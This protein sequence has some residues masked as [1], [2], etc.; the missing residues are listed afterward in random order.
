MFLLSNWRICHTPV[1]ESFPN[2]LIKGATN[3]LAIKS[4]NTHSNILYYYF[5]KH[6]QWVNQHSYE[7]IATLKK[8]RK[9]RE[10]GK[11]EKED[12]RKWEEKVERKEGRRKK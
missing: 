9:G 5:R 4:E 11:E 8:K 2:S 6:S 3:E 7:T 12:G 10:G 1:N